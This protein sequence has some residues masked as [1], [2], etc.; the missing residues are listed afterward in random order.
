MHLLSDSSGTAICYDTF[1]HELPQMLSGI[2]LDYMER[3][4]MWSIFDP[5]A[6]WRYDW[7]I[8]RRPL[9]KTAT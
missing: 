2:I 4:A 3:R 9:P 5:G 1:I 7:F 6:G 8:E